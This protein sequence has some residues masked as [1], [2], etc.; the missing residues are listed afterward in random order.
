MRY[1]GLYFILQI[2]VKFQKYSSKYNTISTFHNVNF[3]WPYSKCYKF[4]KCWNYKNVA[5]KFWTKLF[6][7]HKIRHKTMLRIQLFLYFLYHD[8]CNFEGHGLL[9]FQTCYGFEHFFHSSFKRK[10]FDRE[11]YAL[12]FNGRNV[13]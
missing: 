1:K 12:G 3:H 7:Y 9:N 8:F 4:R 2:Y 13:I 6:L 11:I 10:S 5:C